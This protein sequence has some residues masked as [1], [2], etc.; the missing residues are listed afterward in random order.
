[1]VRDQERTVIARI[2]SFRIV[3][4]KVFKF[5]FI[6]GEL[7]DGRCPNCDTTM[8]ALSVT[9]CP[10]VVSKTS[11]S[12]NDSVMSSD[13]SRAT[14]QPRL[15]PN[16]VL[17]RAIDAVCSGIHYSTS[18][19]ARPAIKVLGMKPGFSSMTAAST[20][21]GRPTTNPASTSSSQARSRLP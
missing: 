5:C 16:E 18:D 2:Y 21:A 1:M 11:W 20:E 10:P 19:I 12:T 13:Q 14:D 6:C 15:M 17:T 8:G 9:R 7:I 4:F 3:S